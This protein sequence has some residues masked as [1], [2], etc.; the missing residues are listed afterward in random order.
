MFSHVIQIGQRCPQNG[1]HNAVNDHANLHATDCTIQQYLQSRLYRVRAGWPAVAMNDFAR[2]WTFRFGYFIQQR[3]A[4]SNANRCVRRN[5]LNIG[6]GALKH[7]RF[8]TF[9]NL[10][11]LFCIIYKR[12]PQRRQ[13]RFHT[14][15]DWNNSM[16]NKSN[17]HYTMDVDALTSLGETLDDSIFYLEKT[18]YSAALRGRSRQKYYLHIERVVRFFTVITYYKMTGRFSCK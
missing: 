14:D 2:F 3:C 13:E 10:S 8:W 4:E 1:T 11:E 15:A 6:R 5:A 18:K 17:N 16:K 12:Q 9:L 7:D